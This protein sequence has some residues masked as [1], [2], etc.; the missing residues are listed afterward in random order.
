MHSYGASYKSI[1]LVPCGRQPTLHCK[2]VNV[3][4][5]FRYDLSQIFEIC[6]PF[7]TSYFQFV[8]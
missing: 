8:A 6:I 3:K 5:F 7:K 4:F 2:P 1:Q